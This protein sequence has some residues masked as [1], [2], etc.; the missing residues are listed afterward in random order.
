[1]RM[2]M[3][4]A[5]ATISD[6][7]LDAQIE[8]ATQAGIA[9]LKEVRAIEVRYD[10]AHRQF[11]VELTDGSTFTFNA[12]RVRELACAAS[13][14]LN[15]VQILGQGFGLHWDALDV[16]LRVASLRAGKTSRDSGKDL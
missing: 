13:D 11:F 10:A 8:Q 4:T 9:A 7:D 12:D 14:A 15:E 1:M 5:F 6:Q 2:K 16:D 3:R